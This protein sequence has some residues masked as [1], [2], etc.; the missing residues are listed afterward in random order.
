MSWLEEKY[1]G[2]MSGRL[3]NFKRKD[4]GRYTF[5]CPICGDSE[6][7][8]KKARGNIYTKGGKL[9]Y[10][11]FNC[12]A[13]SSIPNL[14]KAV[15]HS[16]YSEYTMERLK[17]QGAQ[18][19]SDIDDFVAK[20][21]KPVFMSQGPLKGLR[22][23]SQLSP[24]DPVKRYV[25]SRL[26]P[27][28]YH[29]KLFKCP[30]FFAWSNEV[31]PGKFETGALAHDET[32]LL[33]PFLDKDGTMHAFQGR[34][35]NPGSRTKYITIVNDETRPK[36]YGLD[37]VDLSR[38][39]YV[40]EGPIDSMFVGNSIAAAGGDLISAL[41]SVQREAK[42]PLV[43]VYDNEPRSRHT[44]DKMEKAVVAGYRIVVWPDNVEQKDVNEMVI[45]GLT[46]DHIRY[47]L[48]NNTFSGL[49]ARMALARWRKA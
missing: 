47:I 4:R 1:I 20:M 40:L 22:K 18:P 15:D 2:L 48:E 14:I 23:V 28:P 10:H 6:K 37:T 16:L 26:I 39:T 9:Q 30:N 31:V 46:T 41:P 34:S 12:S 19:R 8:S 33:I 29:A 7:D 38:T 44:L 35:L 17:E 11:C 43:V 3:R 45:S 42:A 25:A 21:R 13:H 32:R 49:Q 27:N 36:V 24:D 5:S